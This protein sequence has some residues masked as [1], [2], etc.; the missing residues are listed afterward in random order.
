MTFHFKNNDILLQPHSTIYKWNVN[1]KKA[2]EEV[3]PV[4][5]WSLRE[6]L[7]ESF[8]YKLSEK[9]TK[10]LYYTLL[11]I[12]SFWN[13]CL[14]LGLFHQEEIQKSSWNNKTPLYHIMTHQWAIMTAL[15]LGFR[16]NIYTTFFAEIEILKVP[17]LLLGM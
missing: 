9:V 17:K 15:I 5:F 1:K 13:L 8:F 12:I 11:H 2:Q 16:C 7:N 6:T 14:M 3:L 10:L 4:S